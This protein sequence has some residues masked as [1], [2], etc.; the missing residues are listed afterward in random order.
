MRTRF[1]PAAAAGLGLFLAAAAGLALVERA[2]T[3]AAVFGGAAAAHLAI[4]AG[5]AAR[6]R[7]A[8]VAGA[9]VGLL[10]LA[11]VVVGMAFIVGIEA[12]IGIDLND[13]WFAPLN[14]YATIAVAAVIGA[15]AVGLLVRGLSA[16]RAELA[17]PAPR[18]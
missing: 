12:G 9:A 3:P 8:A 18:G 5:L 6:S 10:D 1:L 7:A 4:A 16:I 2:S 13:R 15:I 14:G 17:I 11:L